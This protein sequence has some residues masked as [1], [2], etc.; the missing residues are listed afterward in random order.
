ML[1]L[2]TLNI[3]VPLSSGCL[4]IIYYTLY[5]LMLWVSLVWTF[6]F[7]LNLAHHTVIH[8]ENCIGD[9]KTALTLRLPFFADVHRL[10]KL[11]LQIIKV[12]RYFYN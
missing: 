2:G 4:G 6:N 8:T 12:S 1:S 11:I 10:K 5:T 9:F 7:Y 3:A